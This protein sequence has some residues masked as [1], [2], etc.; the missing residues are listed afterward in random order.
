M[1][2]LTDTGEPPAR[3]IGYVPDQ[4]VRWT[5]VDVNGETVIIE[6]VGP[7]SQFEAS[8]AAAQPVVDSFRFSPGR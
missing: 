6:L 3:A 8:V 4:R 2:L 1:L 5:I 7:L